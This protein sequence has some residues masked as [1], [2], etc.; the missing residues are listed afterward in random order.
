MG[1][2]IAEAVWDKLKEMFCDNDKVRT[3]R[4]QTLRR[5]IDNLKMK[6]SNTVKD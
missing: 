2:E 4:L 5:K 3:C 6:D 1:V